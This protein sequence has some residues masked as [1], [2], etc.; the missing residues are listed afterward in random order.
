MSTRTLVSIR[1]RLADADIERYEAAWELV[2][3]LVR[4][5]KAHAWR[6]RLSDGSRTFLEFIEF[7]S[8]VDPR[9]DTPVADAV[10]RLDAI[11]PGTVEE[12]TDAD[13]TNPDEVT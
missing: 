1:R 10:A 9:A 12:W 7:G 13:E 8:N 6:F 5:R 11:A 2:R 3:D 4:E